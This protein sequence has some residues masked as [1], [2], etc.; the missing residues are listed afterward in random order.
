MKDRL[1]IR[2]SSQGTE[3]WGLHLVLGI[4]GFL[5]ISDALALE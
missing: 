1:G 5:K 4:Q 3:G 2:L